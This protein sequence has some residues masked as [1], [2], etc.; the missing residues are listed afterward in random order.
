MSGV[1]MVVTY[2]AD[3]QQAKRA[4]RIGHPLQIALPNIVLGREVVPELQ[5]VDPKAERSL[6]PLST[7]L[8][9]PDAIA[10]QVAAFHELRALM[11][12]GAPEAP[13]VDPAERVLAYTDQRPLI[14]S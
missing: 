3:P 11:Q 13:L 9:D 8:D 4:A 2:V 6:A 7:L 5:F 10:T 12:K 1:P 14:G